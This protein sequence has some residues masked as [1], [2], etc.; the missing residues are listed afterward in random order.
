MAQSIAFSIISLADYFFLLNPIMIHSLELDNLFIPISLLPALG[1][2]IQWKQK[3]VVTK[4]M[5]P[6][7]LLQNSNYAK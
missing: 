5:L 2:V 6:P 7:S 3:K 4:L 1:A